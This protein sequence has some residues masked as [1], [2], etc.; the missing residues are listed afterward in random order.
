MLLYIRYIIGRC[1][2]IK[3]DKTLR[4]PYFIILFLIIRF[5]NWSVPSFCHS[6]ENRNPSLCHCEHRFGCAVIPSFHYVIPALPMSFP[7]RRE[8]IFCISF[9]ISFYFFI[10][11]SLAYNPNPLFLH[12]LNT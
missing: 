10:I 2:I 12:K 5:I 8:S 7:R 11:S 1:K 3:K 9:C 6:C 4:T